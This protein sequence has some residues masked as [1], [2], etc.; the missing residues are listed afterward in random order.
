MTMKEWFHEMF[1]L[2]KKVHAGEIPESVLY[3]WAEEHK[4]PYD[5]QA[6]AQC[7]ME[8]K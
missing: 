1:S 4:A 7:E 2:A 6:K 3:D 5:D 8:A